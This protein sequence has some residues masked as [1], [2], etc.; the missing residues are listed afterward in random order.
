MKH[1]S[2]FALAAALL[3]GSTLAHAAPCAGFT[4]VDSADGF[5]PN[6]E[7]L[8]NRA[9]TL[10]CTST[11]VFCPGN[12]VTRLQMAAFMNRLGTALTPAYHVH[13]DGQ[14]GNLAS[15]LRICQTMD[16]VFTDYPRLVVADAVATV[17]GSMADQL[18]N[19]QVAVASDGGMMWA[20]ASTS[21]TLR[22]PN[23]GQDVVFPLQGIPL[24]V[25]VGCRTASPCSSS[26]RAWAR[27]RA[28][29]ATCG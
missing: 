29:A 25:D 7:W 8:R 1:W 15:G 13:S 19:A 28:P 27:R 17:G 26:P 21:A 23:T 3:F 2:R 18:V 14:G 24:Y 20:P 6:V 4:D 16:Y 12:P 22:V 9:I 11:T 5:C 10:G